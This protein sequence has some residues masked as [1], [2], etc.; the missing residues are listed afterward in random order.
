MNKEIS[1]SVTKERFKV[2]PAVYLILIRDRKILLLRRQNTG[3]EDGNYSLIAGHVDENEG[4][5]RAVLREAQEE[6]GIDIDR[7]KLQLAHVMYR[8]KP[9]EERI[10][11]F[12]I[13]EAWE[14]EPQNME[15][16]KCDD[17]KWFALDNIPQNTIPHVRDVIE[18]HIANKSVYSES[19]F[20]SNSL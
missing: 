15:P 16:E 10:D 7:S 3:F 6:A 9:E 5:T 4:P 14:G 11:L 1:P 18:K 12:F 2:I 17:L 8:K 20:N 13:A 19:G